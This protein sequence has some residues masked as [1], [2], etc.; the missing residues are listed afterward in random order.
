MKVEI[1]IEQAIG[2]VCWRG[3][4]VRAPR[5]CRDSARP[6]T[7]SEPSE[8]KKRRSEVCQRPQAEKA[9]VSLL[10]LRN[11]PLLFSPFSLFKNPL[12][13][14]CQK[15]RAT[16][17]LRKKGSWE[18]TFLVLLPHRITHNFA[19]PRA[20]LSFICFKRLSEVRA[21]AAGPPRLL[22]SRSSRAERPRPKHQGART[23]L[24]I[25][26]F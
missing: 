10:F 25:R 11:S 8:E 21:L 12:A 4:G 2:A 26:H 23:L 24:G 20:P 22:Q 16:H 15:A 7:E 17:A 9:K 18:P 1:R 14:P 19:I 5:F 6:R 13:L 3:N